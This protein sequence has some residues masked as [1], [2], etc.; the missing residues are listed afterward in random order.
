MSRAKA[1]ELLLSNFGPFGQIVMPYTPM[2]RIDSLDLLGTTEIMILAIYDHNRWSNVLDIGANLGLHSICLARLGAN[3][4][5]YEP[6]FEHYVHLLENL[7][8]NHVR[9]LVTPHMAAVSTE[10]GNASFIRLHDNLTGNHL[11]GYKDS[12]GHRE[13]VIVPTVDVRTLWP[14]F[15][16]V[17]IDS[18]GNEADLLLTTT[19]KTWDNL[20]AVVEVRNH[21]NAETI[22]GH[23]MRLRVPLWSQ[24]RDWKRVYQLD[25]MPKVNREGSLFIGHRGPWE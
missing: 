6:D 21:R 8:A 16:F 3:V 4:E 22:F 15:D 18:E 24:K 7:E 17:K 1:Q 19:Q 23:F 25:D 5:A 9:H 2:G 12:Y 10:T 13:T 14:N 20:Q 11:E